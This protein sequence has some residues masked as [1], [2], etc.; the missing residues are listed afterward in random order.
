MRYLIV[1][2][3]GAL[4]QA[5]GGFLRDREDEVVILSRDEHKQHNLRQEGW[6]TLLGDVRSRGDVERALAS[7]QPD[8]IVHLAALKHVPRSEEE[9]WQYIYTNVIGTRNVLDSAGKNLGKIVIVSTDKAVNPINVYGATKM[10]AEK[11][12][13]AAAKRGV[14]V[15]VTRWGNV[16]DSRGAVLEFF[17]RLP[18]GQPTP[19]TDTRM[20]RFWITLEEACRFVGWVIQKGEPG[21]IYV[22]RLPSF[23]VV[24]LA[25]A[26]RPEE[27]IEVVG[28]RPGEKLH[29][30]LIAYEEGARARLTTT[31][32][33]VGTTWIG[34]PWKYDSSTNPQRLSTA[35]LRAKL[36]QLKVLR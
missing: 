33:A 31:G 12:A 32:W 27:E 30:V 25:M 3:T 36:W 21:W 34:K 35:D 10:L 2:G 6:K 5:L 8:V 7:V 22:P 23:R 17:T 14:P 26:L 16:I 19:I 28:V 13:I 4:G 24:D 1:G 15:C 18:K 29:E 9:P 20:T 11:L